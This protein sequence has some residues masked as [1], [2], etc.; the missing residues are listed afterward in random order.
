MSKICFFISSYF[1]YGA[2]N[3]YWQSVTQKLTMKLWSQLL[4]ELQSIPISLFAHLPRNDIDILLFLPQPA[5][6]W[7]T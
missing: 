6:A 4:N 5:Q 7:C 3:V 1:L 2:E